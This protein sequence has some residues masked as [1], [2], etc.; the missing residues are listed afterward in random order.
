MVLCEHPSKGDLQ[1][2]GTSHLS[3]VLLLG[4]RTLAELVL[5]VVLAILGLHDLISGLL[6]DLVLRRQQKLAE[7]APHRR[8]Q[9]T[10]RVGSTTG[11]RTLHHCP[12]STRAAPMASYSSVKCELLIVKKPASLG[13]RGLQPTKMRVFLT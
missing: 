5:E 10:L 12:R 13:K 6:D 11:L 7:L 1:L 9:V 8:L 3:L 2:L 4:L